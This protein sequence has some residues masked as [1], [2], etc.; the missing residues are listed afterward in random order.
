[1]ADW[2]LLID[3]GNTR[4]KWVW[5]RD[6]RIDESSFGRSGRDDFLSHCKPPKGARP[7]GV[8]VSSVASSENTADMIA[9]CEDQWEVP[10]KRLESRASQAGIVNAYES[11]EMLGVDR[12][13]AIVGAAH[14]HGMPVVIMD[15][16]TATT[17]DAVD[18][19]G[20][21]LGGLILPGPDLMLESLA[22]A[23]AMRVPAGFRN[24]E[25]MPSKD[26]GPGVGPAA[27]TSSAIREGVFAA[28]IGALNQFLRHVSAKLTC[29]PNLVL[30]GGAAEGIIDRLE[31]DPVFDPWLVFKGML[32]V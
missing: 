25:A 4:L 13:L 24:V 27:F 23:T 31:N 9:A 16:G 17:L 20:R 28:Q 18:E 2:T 26:A 32:Q 15:L 14:S 8:L 22:S 10:V 1:M 3:M 21:H 30:T 19:R 5:A 6:G 11:P 12:W 29:E 7:G